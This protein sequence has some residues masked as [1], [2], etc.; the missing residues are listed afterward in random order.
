MSA[1]MSK[2]E[3]NASGRTYATR[4]GSRTGAILR[5]VI[6]R[7]NIGAMCDGERA[8][9]SSATVEFVDITDGL[10]GTSSHPVRL[11]NKIA[12]QRD[13]NK[14]SFLY[15]VRISSKNGAVISSVTAAQSPERDNT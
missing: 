14:A 6:A 5:S 10:Y 13:V 11:E 8:P 12:T 15:S 4:L 9:W 3:V 1:V 7:Q 2:V